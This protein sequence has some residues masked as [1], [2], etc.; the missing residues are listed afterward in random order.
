MHAELVGDDDA[1]LPADGCAVA[2]V[3]RVETLG[4]RHR[5]ACA[6]GCPA[7]QSGVA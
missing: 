3:G 4:A 7:S 6:L 1:M 5:I 2:R